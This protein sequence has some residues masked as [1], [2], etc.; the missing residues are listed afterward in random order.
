MMHGISS[1][2]DTGASLGVLGTT[3]PEPTTLADT[4][5]A[6]E[7]ESA[8]ANVDTQLNAG[9]DALTALASGREVDLHGSMIALEQADIAL[10]AMVA[11]RDKAVAA[12]EQMMN[13]SI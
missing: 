1:V 2:A 7:L 10:R 5:F 12:Y 3:A 8:V 4:G 13:L 11:V 6:R 9:D